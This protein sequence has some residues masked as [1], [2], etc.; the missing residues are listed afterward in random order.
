MMNMRI[1]L[2]AMILLVLPSITTAETM[3]DLELIASKHGV[4]SQILAA[5]I[6]TESAG[7][8]W[9]LNIAGRSVLPRSK[10]AACKT[11]KEALRSTNVI[12]IG[13]AQLNVRWNPELFGPGNRFSDPCEAL[14]PAANMDEA[15]RLLRGHYTVTG[16]W[17]RA[18]GRYHRPA[19]GVPADRYTRTVA[20]NLNSKVNLLKSPVRRERAYSKS[21][22][23]WIESITVVWIQPRR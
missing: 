19:G 7:N 5:V 23:V 16:N 20:T 2:L 22:T 4:P 12:D 17:A 6:E 9:A 8:P 18:V 13:I 14:S 10:K 3:S 11:L 15:A 21:S 1:S